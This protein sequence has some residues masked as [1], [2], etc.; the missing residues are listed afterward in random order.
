MPKVSLGKW[1]ERD[2]QFTLNLQAEL[3]RRGKNYKNLM[4]RTGRSQSTI[5]KRYEQPETIT[6]QEL[7]GFIQEAQLPKE[8]VIRL[9]F[10]D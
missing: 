1:T 3:H 5:F 4:R 9:L 2:A 8:D 10:M 7:R 6:V